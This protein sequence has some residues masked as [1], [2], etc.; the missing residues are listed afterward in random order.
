MSKLPSRCFLSLACVALASC[1]GT[2]ESG[3]SPSGEAGSR[4]RS[5]RT[6]ADAPA[7]DADLADTIDERGAPVTGAPTAAL[8]CKQRAVGPSPLRRLT[9]FEY[10]N[11]VAALL[12]DTTHPGRGFAPDTQVGLF[13]NTAEVQT[14][15]VLLA[16]EY[17][18]AAV[19]LAENIKDPKALVGCELTAA[20]C[21]KSFVAK[22]ARRAYRRPPSTAELDE[23]LAVFEQVRASADATTGVRAVIASVLSSPLF[24]FRPEFGAGRAEIPGAE[25]SR[26]YEL[27][28]RLASLLWASV[29]DEVLLDAAED[30]ELETRQQVAAQARRMLRDPQAKPAIA[31]FYEQWFGL[32]ELESATKEASAFPLFSEGLRTAM[33]EETRRFVAHVVWEQDAKLATLLTAPYSFVNGAL[34][35]LYG[36]NGPS[37]PSQYAKTQLDPAQRSGILTQPSVMAAYA[38]TAASSPIKRGKWVRVRMLCQELPDPPPNIPPPPEPLA[39]VSTRERFAMHSNSPACSGCHALIDGLGFGLEHYDGIGAYRRMDQGVAVDAR[40][41][42]NRSADIDGPY[43][44]ARQLAERLATSSEVRDCAPTQWLRYALAR[45]ETPD[46]DCSLASVLEAFAASDGDLRELMVALTQTD[47]FFHYRKPE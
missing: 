7:G 29:P 47:A 26:G 9:H 43:D 39:G 45:R 35:K 6:G 3:A 41:M 28:A 42:I 38:S 25:T 27:A 32:R 31:R 8:E 13:D 2:V 23:L 4:G 40:G 5:T 18:D 11:S 17:L 12:G 20:S 33:L 37:D 24:L 14:V 19:K 34:A 16:E 21:V 10:D 36:V 44:G 22:F 30:G 15:P 46:D 1:M